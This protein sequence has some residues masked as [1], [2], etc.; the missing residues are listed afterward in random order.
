MCYY[1]QYNYKYKS[2]HTVLLHIDVNSEETGVARILDRSPSQITGK[3]QEPKLDLTLSLVTVP[4]TG[5]GSH[6]NVEQECPK[7]FQAFSVKLTIIIHLKFM[8]H[9]HWSWTISVSP[10]RHRRIIKLNKVP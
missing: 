9:N 2:E 3:K 8:Y 7:L 10:T 6:G 4:W 1:A 5:T